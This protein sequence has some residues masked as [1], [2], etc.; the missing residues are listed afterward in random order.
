MSLLNDIQGIVTGILGN[1]ELGRP[2]EILRVTT[3]SGGPGGSPTRST[4]T[5]QANGYFDE[6]NEHN[7]PSGSLIEIGDRL[8]YLDQPVRIQDE[9][10]RNGIVYQVLNVKPVEL[11]AGV[12]IYIAQL[13]S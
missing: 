2:L 1:P 8:A 7:A 11:G 13:R 9:I 12:G 6:I 3:T 4:T 5:I 10:V